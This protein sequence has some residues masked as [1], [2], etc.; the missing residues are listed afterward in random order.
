MLRGINTPE[1]QI[2]VAT[3]ASPATLLEAHEGGAG[4]H[5]DAWVAAV[6]HTPH[7]Y[8]RLPF[9]L[10]TPAVSRAAMAADALLY[11]K[12]PEVHRTDEAE[13]SF[14]AAKAA[15]AAADDEVVEVAGPPKPPPT[16]IDLL[17]DDEAAGG[18]PTALVGTKRAADD[19]GTTTKQ[20]KRPRTRKAPLAH[21]SARVSSKRVRGF[22]DDAPET[23][24]SV[25]EQ[26]RLL[27]AG[28]TLTKLFRLAQDAAATPDERER[29]QKKLDQKLRDADS[30][31]V[32]V[33]KGLTSETGSSV[34]V[35]ATE[36]DV[37]AAG[38]PLQ[39]RNVWLVDLGAACAAAL[40]VGSY[41]NSSPFVVGFYGD[42]NGAKA[43]AA[44]YVDV[45]SWVARAAENTDWAK[46]F[47][48]KYR[49]I[50]EDLKAA[51]KQAANEETALVVVDKD[52]LV[53]RAGG[54]LQLWWRRPFVAE[55][56]DTAA[57]LRGSAAAEAYSRVPK[58]L[59]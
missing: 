9:A 4:V 31:V 57:Y 13:A 54:C 8:L 7:F 37:L 38:S 51:A 12:V 15:Q 28:Q 23:D 41:S 35:G 40:L 44:L 36:V 47:A 5:E 14:R 42:R 39:K 2:E 3:G 53:D 34:L 49:R 17:S 1:V 26:G 43:A 45:V 16:A 19:A 33:Y 58:A 32:D 6:T 46:G 55:T 10:K 30:D 29:A 27:A 11:A 59:A 24:K 48:A 22:D 50:Q 20:A 18:A 21:Y 25:A 56:R 52:A